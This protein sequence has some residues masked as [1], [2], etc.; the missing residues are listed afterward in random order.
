M[1]QTAIVVLAMLG[2][3]TGYC[4]WVGYHVDGIPEGKACLHILS[5]K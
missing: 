4:F 1:L 2:G 3:V 5:V